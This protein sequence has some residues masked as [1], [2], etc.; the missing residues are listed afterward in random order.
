MEAG[1]E[2]IFGRCAV[3]P[4][5]WEAATGLWLVRLLLKP[6]LERGGGA[7]GS[8]RGRDVRAVGP[9]ERSRELGEHSGTEMF[10]ILP[11]YLC[12]WS[13]CS[14]VLFCKLPEFLSIFFSHAWFRFSH[15]Q[16]FPFRVFIPGQ[17]SLFHSVKRKRLVGGGAPTAFPTPSL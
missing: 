12:C 3:R 2:I 9:A 7:D 13:T 17:G 14:V 5:C 11:V 1:V 16:L 6:G 8:G 4:G 15:F 10:E